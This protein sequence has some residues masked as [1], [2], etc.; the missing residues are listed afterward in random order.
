M[1]DD[2]IYENI[3]NIENRIV[4]TNDDQF[5]GNSYSKS[6]KVYSER[7]AI[8]GHSMSIR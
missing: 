3:Y 6:V 4:V 5:K 2:N 8:S 7:S 1:I